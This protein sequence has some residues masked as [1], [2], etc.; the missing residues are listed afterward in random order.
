MALTDAGSPARGAT[1]EDAL[2]EHLAAAKTYL[3]RTLHLAL[4]Q[5]STYRALFEAIPDPYL[6]TDRQGRIRH[7]NRSAEA[8]LG[9]PAEDLVGMPLARLSTVHSGDAI[10]RLLREAPGA[11]GGCEGEVLFLANAD[12]V[13]EEDTVD[14]MARHFM[15]PATGMVGGRPVPVNDRGTFMGF[16]SHMLWDMHHRLSLIH[17][18]VG[19]IVAFRNTGL[20]IP[21]GM[22]S[23]EDLIR[24]EMESQGL[25]VLYEPSAIIHNRGPSTLADFFEQRT[26]VNI[27]ERYMKR[28]FDYDIPTW[29]KRFL[30]NAWLSFLKD[31]A[32]H[33]LKMAGAMSIE[34]FARAYASLH[35]R[36]DKGDRAI[37]QVVGSTKMKLEGAREMVRTQETNLGDLATDALRVST[38][39]DF[40]ITNGGGIRTSV[41]AGDITK[42]NLI[43]V[44]PFGNSVVLIEV[45]GEKLLQAMEHGLRLYP[46]QNGGFPHISGGVLTFDPSQEAGQRVVSLTI[47]GEEVDPQKAYK[48][49]TNDFMAAGGD[50]Y[51]MFADCPVLLYGGTLDE[52]LIQYIQDKGVIEQEVEGRIINIQEAE[53]NK[54][55]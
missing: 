30:I 35:V 49:A 43:E 9:I 40:A 48:V 14:L 46:E 24:R 33:P 4:D 22:G 13:M 16:A 23:D 6:A 10:E 32:A 50:D 31:N 44:F 5:V 27:G 54:A 39:A 1:S 52:A 17:P 8:L 19:E 3:E 12:N 15:D 55:A 11:A 34:A 42:G 41:E 25:S 20:R 26:R 36:L 51:A 7:A 53:E 28:W 29:D 37:W 38:E 2:R 21:T 45:T 47:G 18:K